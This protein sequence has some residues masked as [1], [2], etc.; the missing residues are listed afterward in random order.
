MKGRREKV[1]LSII[2]AFEGNGFYRITRWYPSIS[3]VIGLLA[4]SQRARLTGSPIEGDP[5]RHTAGY[6]P[7]SALPEMPVV[8]LTLA[9]DGIVKFSNND[10]NSD[11]TAIENHRTFYMRTSLVQT[12]LRTAEHH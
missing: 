11:A 6:I 12:L 3:R 9:P 4:G 2:L 8:R 10:I 1:E 5:V 7:V